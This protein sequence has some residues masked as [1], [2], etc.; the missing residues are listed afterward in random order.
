M[1]SSDE[2]EKLRSKIEKFEEQLE[3]TTDPA[4]QTAILTM[5]AAMRQEKVLLMQGEQA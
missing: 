4:K 3:G 1:Q 5:L 2:L